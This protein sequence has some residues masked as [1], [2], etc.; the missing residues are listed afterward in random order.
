M[1]MGHRRG[2]I[3]SSSILQQINFSYSALQ[4]LESN[5]EKLRHPAPPTHTIP[6]PYLK[7]K[8]SKW[9]DEQHNVPTEFDIYDMDQAVSLLV[10]MALL[11]GR[12]A[13]CVGNLIEFTIY[14]AEPHDI[15]QRFAPPSEDYFSEYILSTRAWLE[16]EGALESA[17]PSDPDIS[18][19][20]QSPVRIG[21]QREPPFLL[22]H[23]YVRVRLLVKADRDTLGDKISP[24]RRDYN[25]DLELMEKWDCRAGTV[26]VY[27]KTYARLAQAVAALTVIGG[28]IIP[29]TVLD[30]IAGV[31]P[32]NITMFTWLLSGFILVVAKSLYVRDWPWYDFLAGRVECTRLSDLAD[33]SGVGVQLVLLF[34]LQRDVS[35]RFVT[36]GPYNGVFKRQLNLD[37]KGDSEK[38]NE[39]EVRSVASLV[40]TGGFAIDKPIDLWTMMAAGFIVLKVLNA[41]GEHLICIDG[42][43]GNFDAARPDHSAA[44]LTC[45]DFNEVALER[46]HDS[47]KMESSHKREVYMLQR[48]EFRWTKVLGVYVKDSTFG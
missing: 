11:D 37:R 42:R 20:A 9:S 39:E 38:E 21:S 12:V 36:Q 8:H 41:Q 14:S 30:R 32:F 40:Q 16:G 4:L 27:V 44:W 48:V 3:S 17:K 35:S 1:V 31:D 10:P 13:G 33:V 25:K 5:T 6:K 2:Y 34:F 28:L 45:R 23:K 22:G 47:R 24:L 46:A 26:V 29:F 18:N 19:L 15:I 7:I 43:K